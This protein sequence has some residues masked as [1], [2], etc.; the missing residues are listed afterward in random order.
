MPMLVFGQWEEK[1]IGTFYTLASVRFLNDDLGFVA[2]GNVIFKTDN[3]GDL[4]ENSYNGIGN[5]FFE[6]VFGIGANRIIAVGKNFDSN[7]SVIIKSENNGDSWDSV[8]ISNSAFLRSI[9]FISTNIG[10]CSGGDGTILKTTNGGNSWQ[11]LNSGTSQNLQSIYFIDEMNG[12]AVGG[13]PSSS[14][15]LKT[16]DGGTSW[17]EVNAPTSNNL[18]SVYFVNQMVGY[19]VG[20]NGEIIKTEDS[21]NTWIHQSSVAMSGNLEVTFTDANT[22]Y[23]VGGDFN[24]SLIQK[25]D[26]GGALWE[27]VSPNINQGLVS[28]HFPSFLTG[29]AVGAN[30]TVLKTNSGGVVTAT[31]EVYHSPQILIYPNPVTE[32]LSIKAVDSQVIESLKMYDNNGY[33][34][35]EAAINSSKASIDFSLLEAN[36]YFVVIQTNEGKYSRKILKI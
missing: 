22:G 15:I 13:T 5:L 2:G 14:I 10:Y 9:F 34:M 4:W 16:I 18:Q 36:N 3:G 25:T 30:G 23:I 27:D 12:V 28:I 20:W 19:I 31:K 26:N 6:D 21:G 7:Q 32:N 35:F 1:N 24:E 17:N 29:Y 33:F 8:N 11:P